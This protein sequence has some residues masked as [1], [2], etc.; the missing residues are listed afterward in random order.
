MSVQRWCFVS[1]SGQ[2]FIRSVQRGSCF[3]QPYLDR[4]NAAA[5]WV[6]PKS[7]MTRDQFFLKSGVSSVAVNLTGQAHARCG[8][9]HL[10]FV[11]SSKLG[12]RH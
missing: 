5:Q 4:V 1:W 9:S 12:I 3:S 6:P 11:T 2:Q 10:P 8:R 7:G